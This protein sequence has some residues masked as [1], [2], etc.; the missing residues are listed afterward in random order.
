MAFA[1]Q[2]F[3]ITHDLR[4]LNGRPKN[5]LFD[6]FWDEIKSLLELHAPVDDRRHGEWI[7]NACPLY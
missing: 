2:D 5:K 1:S 6:I 7:D 3:D 4:E